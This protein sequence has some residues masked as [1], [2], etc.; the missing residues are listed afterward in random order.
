MATRKITEAEDADIEIDEKL[1]KDTRLETNINHVEESN[2]LA[3]TA[4]L[5]D[6]DS[7]TGDETSKSEAPSEKILERQQSQLDDSNVK[8]HPSFEQVMLDV[9]RCAGRL[10]HIRQCYFHRT[11]QDEPIED[12][13]KDL[14]MAARD[15]K[16]GSD[17]A[18]S[19]SSSSQNSERIDRLEKD[20][21]CQRRLKRKLANLIVR[22]LI[23]KPELH[24]YQGFHD[25]CLTYM[26]I[27]GDKRAFDKL[28]KLTDSH[29]SQFMRP[30]MI[31]T[32]EFLALIPIIICQH[33]A[34]LA[35][36]LEQAEVGTI[37]ALSWTIT[38]FSHVIPNEHDVETIFSYLE[39][40][41]DPHVILY[42]CA[43][44]VIYK[45]EKIFEL[46]PEMSTVHHF[47]CQVPR[48]ER[49]PIQEL[50]KNAEDS[51]KRW[52]P[53]LIKKKLDDLR[54]AKLQVHNYNLV[55]NLTQQIIPSL[56]SFIGVPTSRVAIVVFV[57][58]SA[59]AFQWSR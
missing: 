53:E 39:G 50:L 28:V 26:T 47:L 7:D 38:W 17:E 13:A 45:K 8:T 18:N 16:C 49:L 52:P 6:H 29:F 33:D 32:Q 30:T 48:K 37:Y 56:A 59:L 58:A 43:A 4:T 54:R 15:D 25:V 51:F 11:D 46:D 3:S 42:L 36:F 44:I 22:L 20:L 21:K 41:E 34:R 5:S 10:E 24:Y 23:K 19:E 55:Q 40:F 9:N 1:E 57:L 35:E 2:T 31:E 27:Y 14:E 12:L